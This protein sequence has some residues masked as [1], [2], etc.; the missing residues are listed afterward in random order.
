MFY[1]FFD[2][3]PVIFLEAIWNDKVSNKPETE[4]DLI[5]IC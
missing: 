4:Y 2:E 5:S 3:P 1:V